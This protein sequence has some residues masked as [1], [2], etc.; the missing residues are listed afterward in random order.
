MGK[1][2]FRRWQGLGK[3]VGGVAKKAVGDTPRAGDCWRPEDW[4]EAGPEGSQTLPNWSKMDI[5]MAGS[6][7]R[8]SCGLDGGQHCAHCFSCSSPNNSMT[9][10]ARFTDEEGEGSRGSNTQSP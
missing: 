3:D 1:G 5:L 6:S 10:R 7:L 9:D 8:A 2:T 4:E